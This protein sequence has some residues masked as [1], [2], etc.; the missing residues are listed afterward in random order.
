MDT[1]ETHMP[2]PTQ[3]KRKSSPRRFKTA[4]DIERAIDKAKADALLADTE[5]DEFNTRAYAL[6]KA[7]GSSADA[8]NLMN[9][10][11]ELRAKSRR[12]M[13]PVLARLKE[14]IGVMLTEAPAVL[15]GDDASIPRSVK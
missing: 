13:G 1:S 4:Q 11:D 15:I 9:R 6:L 3:P 8:K 14:R 2:E 7:G 10:R 12:L 5:A